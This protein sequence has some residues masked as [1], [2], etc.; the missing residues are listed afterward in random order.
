[1]STS[2]GSAAGSIRQAVKY[3]EL[4][5]ICFI[6]GNDLETSELLIFAIFCIK[7]KEHLIT[8]QR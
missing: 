8:L 4:E 2:K 5:E 1:M 3:K 6:I 7:S